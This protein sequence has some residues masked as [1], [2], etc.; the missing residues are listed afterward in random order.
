MRLSGRR[1]PRRRG[2]RAHG[3]ALSRSA[4]R[5]GR[6]RADAG[7][8]ELSATPSFSEQR[9]RVLRELC[10]PLFSDGEGIDPTTDEEIA[11]ATGIP[12]EAVAFELDHLGRALGLE[13]MPSLG[14]RAEMALL[15]MRSGLTSA[16]EG[17]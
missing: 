4:S 3:A 10:R 5:A 17:G 8:G 9:Q 15:A 11:E 14:Q 1:R 7:P 13:D 12:V 2:R 16:D 6:D